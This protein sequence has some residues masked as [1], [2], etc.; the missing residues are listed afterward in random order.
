LA[1]EDGTLN[2]SPGDLLGV[3]YTDPV[4][5]DTCNTSATVQTSAKTKVLYLST[6]GIGSPDQDLDRINPAAAPVDNT[7]AQTALIGSIGVVAV[8]ATTSGGSVNTNSLTV[9][10]TTGAGANRLMLVSIA[11]GASGTTA[12]DAT[13]VT[14]V[15]YGGTALTLVGVTNDPGTRVRCYI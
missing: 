11:V 9:S 14:S 6:D 3:N 4:F 5:G 8:A 1:Q 13:T 7:T 10:H 2:A 15:T 12:N